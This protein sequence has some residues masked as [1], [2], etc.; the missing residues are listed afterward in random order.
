M[1]MIILAAF[2][3]LAAP[4][5][6][7][8]QECPSPP[9]NDAIDFGAPV[10]IE[11]VTSDETIIYQA[12][13]ADDPAERARGMMFRTEMADDEA[14]L[15]L[16]DQPEIQRFW[17]RNT[18]ISLDILHVRGDGV[19]VGIIREAQPFSEV[20]LPSPGPVPAVLEIAGGEAARR[21]IRLGDRVVHEAFGG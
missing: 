1:R 16:D 17:M 21:G 20:L 12:E 14:M 7:S 2:A 18:C 4:V 6:A 10:E 11:V 13:I 19:I 9:E 5:L 8:A 3:V 15:F